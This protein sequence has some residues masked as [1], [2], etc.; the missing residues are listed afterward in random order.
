MTKRD[1]QQY[2]KASGEG[3]ELLQILQSITFILSRFDIALVPIVQSNALENSALQ[4]RKR[5]TTMVQ[6]KEKKKK[7]NSKERVIKT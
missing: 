4:W 3:A 2:K 5:Q 6:F 1:G 7:E